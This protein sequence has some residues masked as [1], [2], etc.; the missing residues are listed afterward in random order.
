[1]SLLNLREK[2]KAAQRHSIRKFLQSDPL[3]DMVIDI[4]CDHI[5]IR[6][7]CCIC[8]CSAVE[9]AEYFIHAERFVWTLVKAS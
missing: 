9:I 3:I 7:S 1:M 6:C 4:F 2:M 8:T 5:Y